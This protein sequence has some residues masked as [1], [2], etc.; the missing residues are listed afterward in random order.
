[1]KKNIL[2]ILISTFLFFSCEK[3]ENKTDNVSPTNAENTFPVELT[4]EQSFEIIY[5]KMQNNEPLT[6]K[7]QH[8]IDE[9]ILQ[10]QR[11]KA[12]EP[13]QK[14][15][16]FLQSKEIKNLCGTWLSAYS[17][18]YSSD[19]LLRTNPKEYIKIFEKDSD[20]FVEWQRNK[21]FNN[22]VHEEMELSDYETVT[23]KLIIDK[24][25]EGKI[26]IENVGNKNDFFL[27]SLTIEPNIIH[28]AD[29]IETYGDFYDKEF[30]EES[31]SY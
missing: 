12:E 13:S 5:K 31:E 6:I 28:L 11:K 26:F 22:Y 15:L 18:S 21:Q 25:N 2:A 30:Y 3:K 9:E 29:E 23:G 27:M 8:I 10:K 19:Y 16:L 1:M 20:Y 7:E 17:N 4:K 24:N 14:C